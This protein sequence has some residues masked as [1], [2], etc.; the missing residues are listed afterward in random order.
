[1]RKPT[2]KAE[3][4]VAPAPMRETRP[5]ARLDWDDLRVF[6]AVADAKSVNKAA[7]T[8]LLVPSSVS[9]R[10]E[11]L[12]ERLEVKLFNRSK[13]GM[14]LTDA[15]DDLRDKALSMQRFADDI[16]RS[17]RAR[18][19][20]EE[21]LVTISAPDGIGTLWLAPRVADFLARNP[22]IQIALDCQIGPATRDGEPPDITL[23]V[24]KSVAQIGDDASALASMHYVLAAAPSYLETYGTPKS[25]ASAAGDHRTLKQ[26]GQISQRATWHKHSSAVDAL[27]GYEFESNS[28]AAVVLALRAGAGI[29]AVPTYLFTLV[30][31]LVTIGQE[32]NQPIKLWLVIHEQSRN[33]ARVAKVAEWLRSIFDTKSNPWFREEFV[34]PE[35]FGTELP[36][37]LMPS[38]AKRKSS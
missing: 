38:A 14:T 7:A 30:P 4:I 33:A 31:E 34:G 18:D 10:I 6:L 22:K 17:V 5:R 28:S 36:D 25:I 24:D 8:L 2:D 9:R 21:G 26:S 1:M 12:E 27:A 15:G 13:T 20:K 11:D 29:C 37:T 16:E 32:R 19:R 23:A 3:G 35:E